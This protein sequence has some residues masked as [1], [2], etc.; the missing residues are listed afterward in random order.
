MRVLVT[1]A[2]GFVGAH[3]ARV[4]VDQGHEVSALVRPTSQLDVLSDLPLKLVLGS[5]TDLPSLERAVRGIDLL[6]HVAADYRFWVPDPHTMH[7]VNVLG[8]E[9]LMEFA[10]KAGVSRIVYTSS[11]VTV[12]CSSG[13]LGTEEDF[14]LPSEARSIYQRTKILAEQAAWRLIGEGAPITIVNPST[15][16][17]ALDR[18][19]TPTGRLIVDFLNGRLPGFLEAA[20]NF[21]PV[22]DVAMGHWLAAT[23]GR[24]GERYILGG[25]NIPLSEFLEI[26]ART[27]RQPAPKMKIPYALAYLAGLFGDLSGGLTGREPRATRDGV[28]MA[29]VPMLFDSGKAVKELG[30]S[31]TPLTKAAEEAVQWFRQHGYVT[32]GGIK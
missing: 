24:V 19:P 27:S 5:L 4:L 20:F 6:C 10:W 31:Q 16:I 28:R 7:E 1:G 15:P 23:S 3:V 21:V 25:A 26:L 12:R 2:T 32:R 8:T 18:R 11:T 30:F 14:V 9:R 22:R 17:G 29:R 13:R